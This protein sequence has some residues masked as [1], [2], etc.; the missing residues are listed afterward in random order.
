MHKMGVKLPCLY[1]ICSRKH[2]WTEGISHLEMQKLRH[3]EV[4]LCFGSAPEN[5]ACDLSPLF[6]SH[7]LWVLT[8]VMCYITNSG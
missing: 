2:L 3:E 4:A 5:Q 8:Y 1:G 7:T 6:L